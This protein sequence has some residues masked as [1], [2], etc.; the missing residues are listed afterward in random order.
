MPSIITVLDVKISVTTVITECLIW[1]IKVTDKNDARW[2]PKIKPEI[3][4]KISLSIG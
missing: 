2:E 3:K 1:L 4:K